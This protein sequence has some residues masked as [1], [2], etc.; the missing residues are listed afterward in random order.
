MMIPTIDTAIAA[1]AKAQGQAQ[2][3]IAFL[4]GPVGAF[5]AAGAFNGLEAQFL[6]LGGELGVCLVVDLVWLN[7]AAWVKGS[8]D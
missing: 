1:L 2:S 8:K 5:F 6:K 7:R 3:E 4:S